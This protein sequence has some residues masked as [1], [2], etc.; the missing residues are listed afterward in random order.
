MSTYPNM[1]NDPELLKIKT[2][3]DEIKHLKYRTEKHDYESII[4]SLKNDIDYYRK[5]YKG[6]K[7]RMYLRSFQKF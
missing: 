6:F 3:D 2:K 1:N 4:K 5:K 7:K